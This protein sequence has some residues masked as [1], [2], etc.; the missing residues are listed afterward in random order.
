MDLIINHP[1]TS[2]EH[3]EE[4]M[5]AMQLATASVF[6]MVLKAAIEL[7]VLEI[8]ARCGPGAYLSAS[9]V[10]SHLSTHN[11]DAPALLDRIMRL[12]ATHSVL[13]C[14][15]SPCGDGRIERVYGLAPV[16]R[17][18]VRNQDGVSIAPLLLLSHDKV[19]MESLHHL[20]DA[21]FEGGQLFDKAHEMSAYEYTSVDLR[22]RNLFNKAM[23]DHS[24]IIM[25]KMLDM[26]KGF[27]RF[28]RVVTVGGGTGASLS[29]IISK[30][31]HI[32]GINFDL[33]HV[34][35]DA[36]DYPGVEHVGG[37]MF[38]SIPSADAILVQGILTDWEDER[39]LDILKNC[40]KVLPESGKVI[41]VE[42]VLPDVTETNVVAQG[43]F[44]ADMVIS[45]FSAGRKKTVKEFEAF[46]R[47]AGFAGFRVVCIAYD[48]WAMECYKKM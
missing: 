1:N 42:P 29:M 17:F 35:A 39:C 10:A 18:L 28:E 40:Y 8:M 33:P 4:C 47:G 3:D 9:E 19:V 26:Y 32:K 20:K 16:C 15:V 38:V 31:P 22:L 27:E 48:N 6:P 12:L 14:T 44:Q 24:T 23:S 43:I 11:P 7:E 30:Y 45:A 5:F 34:V 36:P 46:A 37:D 21:I 25:K 13:T 41:I 2:I